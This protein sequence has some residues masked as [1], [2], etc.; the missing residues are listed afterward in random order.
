MP[1]RMLFSRHRPHSQ[2]RC[3]QTSGAP[4]GGSGGGGYPS[5]FNAIEVDEAN[6][7]PLE[8]IVRARNSGKS[9][10]WSFAGLRCVLSF[11]H[12]D[13]SEIPT[14]QRAHPKD[15]GILTVHYTDGSHPFVFRFPAGPLELLPLG[16]GLKSLM[17]PDL[18]R[19]PELFDV[20]GWR[21]N[22]RQYA[23]GNLAHT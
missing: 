18:R 9:S 10:H 16:G 22:A 21:Y 12:P 2:S 11:Q 15:W 3:E 7:E 6:V 5:G 17:G 8:K 23:L 19:F 1:K 13:G 20:F 4:P 14:G